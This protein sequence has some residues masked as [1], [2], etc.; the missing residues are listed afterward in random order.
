[1]QSSLNKDHQHLKWQPQ[2]S[3]TLHPGFQGCSGQAADAVSAYIQIKMQDSQNVQ[4]FGRRLPSASGPNLGLVGKTQ[5]FFPKGICTVTV[6][7][8]C[9]GKGSLR[10]FGK[11]FKLG[12]FVC[13]PSERT[14]PISVCG[15]YHTGRQD[16]NM[17]PTWKILMKDVDLGE[18]T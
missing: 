4:M 18:Q 7:Q 9:Y 6:W 16:K 12:M 13:Q 2:K 5:S 8:D 3:W 17:E 10:T 15:R 14:L 1:M 11:S